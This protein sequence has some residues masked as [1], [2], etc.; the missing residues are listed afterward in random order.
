MLL[1]VVAVPPAAAGLFDAEADVD[2][3]VDDGVAREAPTGVALAVTGTGV[4]LLI[5]V[6]AGVEPLKR[7]SGVLGGGVVE[8]EAAAA[9]SV[10]RVTGEVSEDFTEGFTFASLEAMAML[11]AEAAA[12]AV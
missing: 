10:G 1:F 6:A 3:D 7:R 12:A 8:P 11:A 9:G 4:D 2:V 5:G